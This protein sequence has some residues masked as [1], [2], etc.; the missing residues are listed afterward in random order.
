MGKPKSTHP[1]QRFPF[2]FVGA[3]SK[4]WLFISFQ[5]PGSRQ[6]RP[7]PTSPGGP[8]PSE[9]KPQT[10]RPN[11]GAAGAKK[12]ERERESDSDL[13]NLSGLWGLHFLG[14]ILRFIPCLLP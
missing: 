10:P 14:G 4:V 6:R 8:G 11:H 5:A 12:G 1:F 9:T 2:T 13:E 3:P 7:G